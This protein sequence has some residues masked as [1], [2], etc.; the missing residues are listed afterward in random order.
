MIVVPQCLDFHDNGCTKNVCSL[1][2]SLLQ[3]KNRELYMHSQQVAN[4]AASMAAKV[5]LSPREI[6]TVKTAALLHDIGHLAIPN[7]ILYKIPFLSSREMSLYKRHSI[8]G[9]SMLENIP[10]FENIIDIIRSHHEKWDGTGYPKRLKA[11][12]IPLGARIIS[13]ANY[14]DRYV[15]PCSQYWCKTHVETISEL[16]NR[17][18]L[19]FDPLIVKAF[20]ETIVAA[21]PENI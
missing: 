9:A 8:A 19:D 20:I 1:F 14:Y 11:S 4:Y 17:S 6:A 10:G 12:N 16:K 2:L 5:G 3:Q 13:V 7:I 18:G 15:N 21:T